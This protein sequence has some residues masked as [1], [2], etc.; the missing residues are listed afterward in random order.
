M[1][2][3]LLQLGAGFLFIIALFLLIG[4]ALAPGQSTQQDDQYLT[5]TLVALAIVM[6]P[7]TIRFFSPK[8]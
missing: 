4:R 3:K 5:Y 8:K 2:F 7:L 6:I 1:L